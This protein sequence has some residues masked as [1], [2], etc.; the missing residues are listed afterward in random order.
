MNTSGFS[1]HPKITKEQIK[2]DLA[3]MGISK[4][5]H[6]GVTLSFKSIGF[7]D[8][9]PDAFIDALLEVVGPTGTIMM[10]A[11]TLSFP[12]TEIP[13]DYVFDPESTVPYTGLAPRTF[14][15]REA[16]VR[17]RHP[18]GSVVAFGRLA[19]YL[20]DGHDEST[21]TYLPYERLAQVNGK[22]LCIGLGDSL[23]AIRHEAQQRAGLFIV[24][25]FVGSL[26]KNKKGETKLFVW[27]HPPC[28]E[29][30]PTL[31]PKVEKMG[32]IK[33]SKIGEAASIVAP[34]SQLL[35]AMT[36]LLK[37]DPTLTLCNNIF[38]FRCRELERRMNLYG[39]IANPLFFQKSMF[40]RILLS[41]RNKLILRRYSYVSFCNTTCKQKV[42]PRIFLDIVLRR[43]VWV[44]LNRR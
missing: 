29:N 3:R 39:R 38:C 44:F 41:L 37:E 27:V 30:L 18:V 15:K 7:V 25:M 26:Y 13:Y 16:S 23:V 4:G 33:R 9:G 32:I 40:M 35:D 14:V 36:A 8:G 28:H 1:E 31:V 43:I 34:A 11:F 19:E 20:T 22:Y 2:R 42:T 5:D 21:N 10:N 12:I 6:V 17:S 24:P